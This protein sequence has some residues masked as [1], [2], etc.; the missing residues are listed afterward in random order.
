[1]SNGR[2]K[3]RLRAQAPPHGFGRRPC[4]GR[5][6][7]RSGGGIDGDDTATLQ[8]ALPDIATHLAADQPILSLVDLIA[9]PGQ[10]ES[11]QA[12]RVRLDLAAYAYHRAA[13][14]EAF[15]GQL[16]DAGMVQATSDSS[17][18]GNFDAL[19]AARNAF[20][21]DTL[22]AR[23]LTSQC[24]IGWSLAIRDPVR[25][26]VCPARAVSRASQGSQARRGRLTGG[27][28]AIAFRV[29]GA[30]RSLSI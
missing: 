20:A 15:T 5:R 16:D 1:L 3:S 12:A 17:R 29:T 26:E 18:P 2:A 27:P 30:R 8:D 19:A 22:L 11:P 13:P 28:P 24:R 4:G 6:P 25:P 23:N 10:A 21:T 7:L 14:Q 9:K